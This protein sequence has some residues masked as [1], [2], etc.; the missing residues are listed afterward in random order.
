MSLQ[1]KDMI[2]MAPN[3]VELY[4]TA[5]PTYKNPIVQLQILE[6]PD[7]LKY[8]PTFWSCNRFKFQKIETLYTR[9]IEQQIP[10]NKSPWR[11]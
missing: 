1:K 5:V 10:P 8:E 4:D 2:H 9:Q 7:A 11:S 6:I 3:D